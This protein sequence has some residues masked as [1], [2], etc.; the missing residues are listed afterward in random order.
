M[1]KMCPVK[2]WGKWKGLLSVQNKLEF[3]RISQNKTK[4]WP[5]QYNPRN[6]VTL[7]YF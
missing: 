3:Y 5:N 1:E 4:K 2:K 7:T 6:Y